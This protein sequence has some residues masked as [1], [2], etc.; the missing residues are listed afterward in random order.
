MGE[1]KKI[2]EMI[3]QPCNAVWRVPYRVSYYRDVVREWGYYKK[4]G[5][6]RY[7][8]ESENVYIKRIFDFHLNSSD[9]IL[10]Y[11]SS[12]QRNCLWMC[13]IGNKYIN[14][15]APADTLETGKNSIIATYKS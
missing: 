10:L 12:N 1:F 13:K 8:E 9:H 15:V 14:I 2:K 7:K 3:Q 6:V 5:K 11:Y 4:T